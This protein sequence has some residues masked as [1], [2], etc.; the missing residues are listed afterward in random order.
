MAEEVVARTDFLNPF[1]QFHVAGIGFEELPLRAVKN[2]EG[3]LVRNQN[4]GVLRD[5]FDEPEIG[6]RLDV[7]NEHGEA[8]EFQ[9]HE[10]D[11]SVGEDVNRLVRLVRPHVGGSFPIPIEVV[12]AGH[13]DFVRVRQVLNP[14]Q[15]IPAVRPVV[16][17]IARMHEDVGRRQRPKFPMFSVG[18]R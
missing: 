7:R 16:R 9:P 3:R 15:K 4:I 10:A 14:L 11:R 2:A 17:T 12:V 1:R 13:D 8:V 5:V 6:P 18:I